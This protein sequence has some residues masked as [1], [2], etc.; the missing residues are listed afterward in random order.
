MTN[1]VYAG[2]ATT[3]VL[4]C[5]WDLRRGRIPNVLTVVSAVAACAVHTAAA[6][7]SGTAFGLAGWVTGLVLFL[8]WFL[9]R[10]LGGGDVKLFAAFGAWLGPLQAVWAGLFAMVAG[11]AV[12]LAVVLWRRRFKQ[13]MR[14]VGAL[15]L[16]AVSGSGPAIGPTESV[17]RVAYAVPIAAG[18]GLALWLR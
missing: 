7:V 3:A 18:V 2:V 16:T 13:T 5:A 9:A 12:A 15:T 10:G 1:L 8:P 14:A 4:S 11:G 6:G 17:G